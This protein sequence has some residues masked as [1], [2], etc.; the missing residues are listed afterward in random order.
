M[1]DKSSLFMRIVL[2]IICCLYMF[3]F[4]RERNEKEKLKE[5]IEKYER[6]LQKST[7]VK[8]IRSSNRR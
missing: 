5:K 4:H 7:K 3:A 8:Q 2:V 6:N 1:K